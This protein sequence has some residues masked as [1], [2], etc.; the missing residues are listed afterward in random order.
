M[1]A[2]LAFNFASPAR[3]SAEALYYPDAVEAG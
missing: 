3:H 1:T 2:L